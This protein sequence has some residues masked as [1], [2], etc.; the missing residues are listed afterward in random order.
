V[1]D[2]RP[3]PRNIEAEK[4]LLG[5]VLVSPDLFVTVSDLLV[6][7]DFAQDA[8]Q[9]LWRAF[10]GLYTAGTAIDIVT[11]KQALTVAG[12]L[13][14]VGFAYA[15]GLTD[16][17]PRSTHLEHYAAIV[18]EMSGRRRMVLASRNVIEA[19]FTGDAEAV[20]AA[21]A[22]VSALGGPPDRRT[23]LDADGQLAA[24][25]AD[26]E[27][28]ETGPRV[29]L[30]LP[31]I[32]GQ[33]DGVRPGE[34]LGLMAR[35][36]L[37]KTLVLCHAIVGLM[38]TMGV[39][40]FSLEMPAPQIVRRLARM[41]FGLS[42]HRLRQGDLDAAAYCA[43]FY[44]LLLDGSPGLTVAQMSARV[45]RVK[46]TGAQIRVVCVDH[47]G[48][49][50]GDRTMSTYDRVST[51][52]RE[53]KEL[54]KREEVAVILLIQVNRESG[55]DGS[56]ELHLGSARDSGVVEEA[57][58]YLVAMRRL[59]RSTTLSPFDREKYRDVLFAKV[60]K[61]RHGGVHGEETAYRLQGETLRLVE[62]THLKADATDIAALAAR[63]GGRR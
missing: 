61:H 38:E 48:L 30:G 33:L 20:L 45:R 4:A 40:C 31:A 14:A 49:I 51:H 47:L 10:H 50:G 3:L 25:M 24:L 26:L 62:D 63:A 18:L 41:R 6:E 44:P 46:A 13:D 43:W 21:D 15:I 2:D 5:S 7:T 36:G 59:D 34:I 58:D 37:G 60:L 35:P 57:L 42:N 29:A 39:V 22:V 54:A 1:T 52:A 53:L 12:D 16:G 32:D 56:R 28:D 23:M 55:G 27:R 11:V 19:C 9:R 8:H 17:V